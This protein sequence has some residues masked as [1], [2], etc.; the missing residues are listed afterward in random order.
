VQAIG[1]GIPGFVDSDH[2][3]LVWT[4]LSF[5]EGNHLRRSFEDRLGL[6]IRYDNDAR[7][8]ALGVEI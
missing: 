3:S 6:P 4:S 2:V 5:L 7:L 1:V 8:V